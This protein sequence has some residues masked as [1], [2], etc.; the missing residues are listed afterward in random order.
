VICKRIV[1]LMGG[2][3][4]VRSEPGKGSTFWFSVPLLKAIGDVA[5]LRTDVHG[6]RAMI[7]TSDQPCC[8]GVSGFFST[9]GV[10]YVQTSVSAEALA[11]LRSAGAMGDTWAYD[12]LVLDWAR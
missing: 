6:S 1:D 12:F 3:I 8:A 5:P 10:S 11:K 4:G 7:V 9:W 2:Q